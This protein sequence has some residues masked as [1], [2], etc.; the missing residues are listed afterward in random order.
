MVTGLWEGDGENTFVTPV[1]S[2]Q[3]GAGGSVG[4]FMSDC[5]VPWWRWVV[6]MDAK[7]NTPEAVDGVA[8]LLLSNNNRI[9]NT[10][11]AQMWGNPNLVPWNKI[12][13]SQVRDHVGDPGGQWRIINATHSIDAD[14]GGDYTT[15]CECEYIDSRYQYTTWW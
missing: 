5:I 15:T 7:L 14:S 13:L 2:V 1:I 8:R 10:I 9:R 12:S 4:N 6:Y 11:S 3:K